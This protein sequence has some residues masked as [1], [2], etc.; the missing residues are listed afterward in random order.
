LQAPAIFTASQT[1]SS[2]P[3]RLAGTIRMA[4]HLGYRYSVRVS[5]PNCPS[6]RRSRSRRPSG[7]R[8]PLP[9]GLACLTYWLDTPR[10]KRH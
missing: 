2:F 7:R 5:R 10:H 9:G 8:S 4:T 1:H 3:H 6:M